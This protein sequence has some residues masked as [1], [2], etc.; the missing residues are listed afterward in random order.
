MT[1]HRVDAVPQ[2]IAVGADRK[3]VTE[4]L[5]PVRSAAIATKP[6]GAGWHLT[7]PIGLA[8]AVSIIAVTASWIGARAMYGDASLAEFRKALHLDGSSVSVPARGNMMGLRPGE[9]ELTLTDDE[10]RVVRVAA[11]RTA[12]TNLEREMM[13]FLKRKEE[14]AAI[15]FRQDIK[16][17]FDQGFADSEASLQAYADWFFAWERSWVMMKEAIV[18]GGSEALNIFSPSKIWEAVSARVQGYLMQNYQLRVLRPEERNPKIQRGLEAAFQKAHAQFRATVDE[19]DARERTFIKTHTRLLEIYPTGSVAVKLDWAAQRW[20]IP[21]HYAEDR[22]EKVYR[23]AAIMGVS[24]AI[25]PLLAPVISRIG[26][27]V[28]K[29]LAGRVIASRK[30]QILGVLL[31]PESIGL[32]VL[33]G[34][35]ADYAINKIDEKLSRDGFVQEH[36]TA[37]AETRRGWEQLAIDQ[38]GPTIAS[39]YSDTRHSVIQVTEKKS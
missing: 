36:R 32:S 31:A 12:L 38:L 5:P 17:A 15:A 16:S 13:F 8:I 35:G 20:K 14:T 22:A 39:W 3:T 29:P 34:L 25:G 28:L 1:H 7:R 19:I 6:V 10:G 9:I 18:A 21:A 30:G 23:S 26:A 2:H 4:I 37:L 33:V 27:K 24:I 11:Q